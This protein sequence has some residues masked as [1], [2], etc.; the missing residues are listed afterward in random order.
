[1]LRGLREAAERQNAQL[2]A[3]L[4]PEER[5]ALTALLARLAAAHGLD[6]EVHR[7]YRA[8]APG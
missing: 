3:P 2:L 1:M 6:P 5:E 8:G 7:G 4:D